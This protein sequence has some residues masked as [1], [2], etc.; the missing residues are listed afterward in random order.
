[1]KKKM[2]QTMTSN[3]MYFS[4]VECVLW[5]QTMGFKYQSCH[6]CMILVMLFYCLTTQFLS[7]MKETV[8]STS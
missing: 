2:K 4:G 8:V 5:S 1:M 7:K 3:A 6:N